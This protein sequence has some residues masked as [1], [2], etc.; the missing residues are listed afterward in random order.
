MFNILYIL[1]GDDSSGSSEQPIA[2]A[3]NVDLDEIHGALRD[4]VSRLK[5]AEGKLVIAEFQVQTNFNAFMKI[6]FLPNLY[7]CK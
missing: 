3:S 2:I 5:T 1:D 6:D 4:L 7:S